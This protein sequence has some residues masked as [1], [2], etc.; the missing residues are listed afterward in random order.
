MITTNVHGPLQ[1]AF[2]NFAG[3]ADGRPGIHADF[4]SGVTQYRLWVFRA[5]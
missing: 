4:V 3:V 5:L 2:L 1:N